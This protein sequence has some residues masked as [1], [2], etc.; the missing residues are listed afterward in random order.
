MK[1]AACDAAGE[2]IKMIDKH[3]MDQVE[4][5]LS[6]L[7]E[8]ITVID[9]DPDSLMYN[10]AYVRDMVDGVCQEENGM[11]Y[12]PVAQPPLVLACK[13]DIPGA[14]N[15]LTLAAALTS[16]MGN[17]SPRPETTYTARCCWVN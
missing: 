7:S 11:L 1:T 10:A 2:E 14:A 4:D 15:I 5:I 17:V 9:K 6:R 13:A 12:L 8:P 16:S 3:L